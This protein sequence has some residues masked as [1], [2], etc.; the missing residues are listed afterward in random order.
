ME[1]SDRRNFAI[2][3]AEGFAQIAMAFREQHRSQ[4]PMA[5]HLVRFRGDAPEVVGMDPQKLGE[6]KETVALGIR[7]M[8]QLLDARYVIMVNEAWAS[9]GATEEELMAMQAWT[10]SGQS[11][12]DYPGRKEILMVSLDGPDVS[13]ML[14]AEIKA[15]GSVGELERMEGTEMQG[16][17]AGLSHPPAP[18]DP[19][20]WN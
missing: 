13:M 2:E 6:D 1:K 8:V 17:L 10:S 18:S 12:K 11:L 5:V 4:V 3:V 15:D 7:M 20:L 9:M 16:R 14:S 19:A